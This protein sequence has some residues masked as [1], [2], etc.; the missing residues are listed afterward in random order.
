MAQLLKISIII[1]NSLPTASNF[2]IGGT[3]NANDSQR[4]PYIL[5]FFKI[6]Y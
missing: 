4:K 6:T 5:G 2:Q 1:I 3:I